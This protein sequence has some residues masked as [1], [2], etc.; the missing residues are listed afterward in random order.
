L[1][2][3]PVKNLELVGVNPNPVRTIWIPQQRRGFSALISTAAGVVAGLLGGQK[4]KRRNFEHENEIVLRMKSGSHDAPRSSAEISNY[5]LSLSQVAPLDPNAVRRANRYRSYDADRPPE[6]IVWV[7]RSEHLSLIE[8]LPSGVIA[9]TGMGG[10]GKSAL[11]AKVV[12]KWRNSNSGIFWDWRDCREQG[13][14]LPTQLASIL[15]RLTQD[16]LNTNSLAGASTLDVCR[17]FFRLLQDSEGL[18][19][20]DNVDHYVDVETHTFTGPLHIFVQ[21]ALRSRSRFKILVTCRPR[22]SY[23]DISFR[24]VPLI[25]L[26]EIE[27]LTLFRERRVSVG[28]AS[29]EQLREIHRLTR[30]HPFWL[31]MLA[32]EL[33]RRTGITEELIDQLKIGELEG[34]ALLAM[35]RPIWS[36]LSEREQTILS[37]LSECNRPLSEARIE[38]LVASEIRTSNQFRRSLKAVVSLGLVIRKGAGGDVPLYETHPVVRGYLRTVL[39]LK[40]RE[41]FL[42]MIAN[43][44]KDYIVEVSTAQGMTTIAIESYELATLNLETLIEGRKLVDAARA[45]RKVSERFIARGL[46]L[47]YVRIASNVIDGFDWNELVK[48]DSEEVHEFIRG[49]VLN[50]VEVGREAD[51]RILITRYQPYLLK[52]TPFRIKWYA[53]MCRME[54]LLGHF[55]EAVRQGTKGTSLKSDS[56][57]D[58]DADASYVLNLA[59]RDAGHADQALKYY[60]NGSDPIAT[61]QSGNKKGTLQHSFCGNVGRCLYLQGN[62]DLATRYYAKSWALLEGDDGSIAQENRGWAALWIGEAFVGAGDFDR[63]AVFLAHARNIWGVWLPMKLADVDRALRRLPNG[64]PVPPPDEAVQTAKSCEEIMVSLST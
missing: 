30:G 49:L 39:G 10:Q 46:L 34:N 9:I 2:R 41:P 6:V 8:A 58:T 32:A 37:V 50:F 31:T 62:H 29:D 5:D 45:A 11:A 35:L 26:T 16:S 12:E 60:L 56:N 20:F 48:P 40:E 43:N 42:N 51:A 4:D 23:A 38:R 36:T 59:L 19:V 54:W 13:D 25:G 28:T 3:P 63:A 15:S 22:V 33:E 47:E 44:T 14:R 53:A 24:E 27:T 55:D 52:S 21:E 1:H 64:H 7:G 18:L 17:L 57:I 61:L